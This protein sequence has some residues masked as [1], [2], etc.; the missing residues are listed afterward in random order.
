M[1]FNLRNLLFK[2]DM[3]PSDT[4]LLYQKVNHKAL[5]QS[6]YGY[7][8]EEMTD[9]LFVDILEEKGL[10]SNVAEKVADFYYTMTSKNLKE[11]EIKEDD[12]MQTSGEINSAL[13]MNKKNPK[14][15]YVE[16][17]GKKTKA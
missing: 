10:P 4:D 17:Y 8:V 11:K 9:K 3:T 15:N 5:T 2:Y 7:T 1:A 16:L 12:G 6:L 13:G 14:Y